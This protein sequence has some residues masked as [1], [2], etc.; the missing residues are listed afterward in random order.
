MTKRRKAQKNPKVSL[1]V[2]VADCGLRKDRRKVARM[3]HSRIFLKNGKVVAEK[4]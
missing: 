3:Q 4:P 1:P 2:S